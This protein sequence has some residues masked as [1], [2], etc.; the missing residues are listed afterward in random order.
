MDGYLWKHE[1]LAAIEFDDRSLL[2]HFKGVGWTPELSTF[3]QKQEN[4]KN[5]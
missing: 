5:A 3:L 2:R 4:N 1:L